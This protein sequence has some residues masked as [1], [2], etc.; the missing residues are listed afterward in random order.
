MQKRSRIKSVNPVGR[1]DGYAKTGGITRGGIKVQT[2][3]VKA[4]VLRVF[5]DINEG[6]KYLRDIAE[7]D[8]PL[9]MSLVA[10][11]VPTAINVDHSVKTDLGAAMLEAQ[12]R[13]DAHNGTLLTIDE[14][15][16]PLGH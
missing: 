8:R 7:T 15:T 9:F 16:E 12:R 2:N 1:P 10:K 13:V 6:D 5:E 4:A 3:A 14:T 11:L